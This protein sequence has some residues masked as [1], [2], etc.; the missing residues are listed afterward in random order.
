MNA[1]KTQII[2]LL[3]AWINQR[4]GLDPRNY[5]SGWND[6]SGRAAYFSESRHITTQKHEATKLLRAVEMSQITAEELTAAFHAYS[7]RLQLT[8][9]GTEYRLDY[10]TGQYFP[11]EYRAAACAVLAQA[12]WD[13]HRDDTSTGDSLRSKFNRMFGKTIANKWF[14]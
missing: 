9:T 3:T 6:T 7:G 14:N 1:T 2:S 13:Y 8:Q 4:P 5:I 12:L 11:T 10:C